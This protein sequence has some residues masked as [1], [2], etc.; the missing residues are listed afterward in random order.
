MEEREREEM[1]WTSAGIPGQS[2]CPSLGLIF[3]ICGMG[4]EKVPA[5]SET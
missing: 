2:S 5:G 1:A 4:W 3:H